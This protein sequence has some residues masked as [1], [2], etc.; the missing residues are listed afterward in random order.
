M[1]SDIEQLISRM[2]AARERLSFDLASEEAFRAL[3]QLQAR[4]ASGEP[5]DQSAGGGL[6]ERLDRELAGRA[7]FAAYRALEKAIAVLERRAEPEPMRELSRTGD[8]S[9]EVP[10]AMPIANTFGE[11]KLSATE[12]S[13]GDPDT[14]PPQSIDA[15]SSEDDLTLIAGIDRELAGVLAASDIRSFAQI[16]EWTSTDVKRI[17]HMNE[18][19]RRINAENWI[20][21]AKILAGGGVTYHARRRDMLAPLTVASTTHLS[22]Q[23]GESV[24]NVADQTVPVDAPSAVHEPPPVRAPEAQ[25]QPEPQSQHALHPIL[26]DAASASASGAAAVAREQAGE[27]DRST[28]F[29]SATPRSVSSLV[30][31]SIAEATAEVEPDTHTAAERTRSDNDASR[32]SSGEPT[33]ESAAALIDEGPSHITIASCVTAVE[34]HA[35]DDAAR[36]SVEPA[37]GALSAGL[38]EGS[39]DETQEPEDTGANA[40]NGERAPGQ[41]IGPDEERTATVAPPLDT[42]GHNGTE[43]SDQDERDFSD[44]PTFAQPYAVVDE[45]EIK[46]AKSPEFETSTGRSGDARE[47]F[48]AAP[49]DDRAET[50]YL[51]HSEQARVGRTMSAAPETPRAPWDDVNTNDVQADEVTRSAIGGSAAGTK[52]SGFDA[53]EP[54]GDYFAAV[55]GEVDEASVRIVRQGED[56]ALSQAQ[57]DDDK[58]KQRTGLVRRFVRVL[59]GD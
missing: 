40:L 38:T 29:A 51:H 21:Q 32:E 46:I 4:E 33:L 36:S 52:P 26:A 35:G 14:Q 23:S 37:V 34:K 31:G 15:A 18:L 12:E 11:A 3:T 42:R 59:R 5:L 53:E 45:A 2:R 55:R 28:A 6:R 30:A 22:T 19:G 39:E 17:S 1:T 10:A 27:Q 20:E 9:T 50:R 49:P 47:P 16:A 57:M 7:D 48:T 13:T 43:P 44:P 54:A 8:G 58:P 56:V 25:P 41:G 24:A